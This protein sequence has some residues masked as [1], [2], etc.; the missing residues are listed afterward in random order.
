ML[1]LSHP[2]SAFQVSGNHQMVNHLVAAGNLSFSARVT[3][4]LSCMVLRGLLSLLD[5]T[6]RP[7]GHSVPS[8]ARR[9]HWGK[10]DAFL[11]ASDSQ[12]SHSIVDRL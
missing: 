11:S 9:D 5:V 4:W 3:W 6:V 1:P 12:Y 8:V 2:K 7:L 10:T